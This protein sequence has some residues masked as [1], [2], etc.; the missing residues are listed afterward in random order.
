MNCSECGATF[1]QYKATQRFCSAAHSNKYHQKKHRE[2]T[3]AKHEAACQ[4]SST[5]DDLKQELERLRE[6][7][8][9]LTIDNE[10]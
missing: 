2:R 4:A 3:Q 5:S 1:T 6:Q 10:Q 8:E 7:N 9:S